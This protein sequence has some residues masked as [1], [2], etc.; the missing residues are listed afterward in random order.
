MHDLKSLL[1]D[2]SFQRWLSNKAP[3]AERAKW[4][5]W[6][7]AAP[8]NRKL[9][10]E[11]TEVWQ[12]SQFEK[13]HTPELDLEWEKLRTRLNFPPRTG[14]TVAESVTRIYARRSRREAWARFGAVAFAF[15]ILFA[16]IQRSDLFKQTEDTVSPG[17]QKLMKTE[18]G[19]RAT[20]HLPEGVTVILNAN[21][22]LKYPADWLG[23]QT[24]QV[25]LQGEAYFTVNPAPQKSRPDFWVQTADGVA[26]V[27]GTQFVV[28]ERG[29]GTR[30]VVESGKVRVSAAEPAST[31]RD[32][33]EFLLN[34]G[35]LME[36]Q[37]NNQLAKPRLVNIKPYTT[38]WHEEMVL[39]NTPFVEVV[40]RI[41]ETYGVEVRVS[42]ERLLERTLSGSI[43][44]QN[45]AIVTDALAKALQVSVKR[46]G[47]TIVFGKTQ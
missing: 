22:S 15:A 4:S 8:E 18:F 27:V 23:D 26:K 6:L 47:Q 46:N 9:H 32:D 28:Y 2:E 41:E 42:D 35:Y 39:D 38:W 43:E 1:A 25:E 30:V 19:Q 16:V 13:A 10:E 20:I 37:K 7:T 44:N 12:A 40:Q 36:F 29:K 33:H 17:E 45:L 21:S 11:A 5:A 31:D 3:S 34:P 24:R 14:A